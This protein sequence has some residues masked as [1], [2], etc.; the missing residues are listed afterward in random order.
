MN[1]SLLGEKGATSY[2]YHLL[3]AESIGGLAGYA[4]A[5]YTPYENDSYADSTDYRGNGSVTI[6]NCKFDM[7]VN[8]NSA[9]GVSVGGLVGGIGESV[10]SKAGKNYSVT[11]AMEGNNTFP[12]GLA[13][14]GEK[15]TLRY[16]ADCGDA[17]TQSPDALLPS[18]PED[19]HGKK[20]A[21]D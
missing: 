2:P 8:Q 4:D 16:S 7:T 3:P 12:E 14:I 18:A 1:L 15:L 11:L 10:T 19:G 13:D 9:V 21:V 5:L 20:D 6:E 17:A